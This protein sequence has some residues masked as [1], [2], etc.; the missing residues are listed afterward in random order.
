MKSNA[1]RG[2]LSVAWQGIRNRAR[3]QDGHALPSDSFLQESRTGNLS[4]LVKK[5]KLARF[6]HLFNALSSEY[7]EVLRLRYAEGLSRSD[8]AY[9]LDTPGTTVKSRLFEGLKKLREHTKLLDD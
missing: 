2:S 3:R 1:I 7:R 4:R 5:E 8:I 9:I 6:I